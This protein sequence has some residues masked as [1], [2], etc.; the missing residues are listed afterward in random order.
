MDSFLRFL[1][2]LCCSRCIE[3]RGQTCNWHPISHHTGT[4]TIGCTDVTVIETGGVQTGIVCGVEP[5]VP[6]SPSSGAVEFLFN[7]PISKLKV[8]A[9]SMH[10]SS[11]HQEEVVF[12]ANNAFY[13]LP[14]AGSGAPQCFLQAIV[15]LTGT[16]IGS[17]SE[18]T[19]SEA[20]DIVI[21]QSMTQAKLSV[22]N[23]L[24]FPN[25]TW[26]EVYFCCNDCM[27]VAGMLTSAGLNFCGTDVASF[28]GA[29]QT[30]LDSD[31]LLQYILF[32]DLSDTLGSIIFTSNDPIF[33]FAPP[34]QTGV[35]YFAAAIAGNNLNGN[36]DLNDPCL[37]I[38]NAIE[39]EWHP[40]PTVSF[41]IQNSEVCAG[42]CLDFE[43]NFTGEAPFNL[44]FE[45]SFSGQQSQ[46]FSAQ[47]GILQIC[48]PAGT[49]DGNFNLSAV[50]LSDANC[51]CN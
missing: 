31:D 46:T 9:A 1:L 4:Q 5:Y 27:T 32:S 29:T 8:A 10:N 11:F 7:P 51:V 40:Q 24:G 50:S 19:L 14:N 13:F 45:T 15:S 48:P 6:G 39:I 43:V 30:N 20:R 2:V 49:P 18:T 3:I 34:L 23:L 16:L 36:V 21:D 17:P 42:D 37:D 12:E 38:S 41:S 33:A 47:N 26:L 25:G 22:N 35:T 28:P 44:T